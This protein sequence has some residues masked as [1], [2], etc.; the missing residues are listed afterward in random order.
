MNIYKCLLLISVLACGRMAVLAQSNSSFII[1]IASDSK[2]KSVEAYFAQHDIP[3]HTYLLAQSINAYRIEPVSKTPRRAANW[4]TLLQNC[5]DI[6][7]FQPNRTFK[8]R[9]T[10]PNDP[11]YP[12]QWYLDLIN[13]PQAWDLTTGIIESNQPKPVIGVLEAG[14]DFTRPDFQGILFQNPGEIPGNGIDDD[15]NGYI[16]DVN[17]WNFDSNDGNH[18]I[19]YT[20]HG[21]AVV[22]IMA[23]QG[24]NQ[25]GT[26]GINWQGTILPLTLEA[27]NTEAA[28]IEAYEYF[29]QMR[30]KYNETS[31]SQG[32]F[33]VATNNSFGLDGLFEEDAPIFC[34]MF[35]KMGSV[36]I[37][38]VGATSNNDVNVDINGDLPS[39]C[40]SEHLIIVNSIDRDLLNQYSGRGVMNVDLA[41]PAEKILVV[42]QPGEFIEDS[43]TSFA[44]PQ[45]AGV[46]SLAYS[47]SLDSMQSAIRQDPVS[48]AESV[49]LCLL[50]NTSPAPD[51]VDENATG[52]YLNARATLECVT[53]KYYVPETSS[54]VSIVNMYPNATKENLSV[55]YLVSDPNKALK[56]VVLDILG[57]KLK[58]GT[59]NPHIDNPFEINVANFAG[60][61]YVL[62]LYQDKSKSSKIF[63]KY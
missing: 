55:E 33:I 51:L 54:K 21:D 59:V 50:D 24:N 63:V 4:T 11:K 1:Q 57:K 41:A 5:P 25:I 2:I 13:M 32:A 22:A 39:D 10:T 48:V 17:G 56:Y 28:T 31:G 18:Y 15:G 37:L 53:K 58:E 44:A 45:I 12:E 61:L 40:S 34:S 38:S 60:G 23:A 7:V 42:G 35:E 43:G 49:K 29:Y 27:R 9:N 46:I 19:D 47:L 30:K 14:Y 16:D 62:T 26:T 36:G 6:H 52:G 20:Y 8:R 3:V